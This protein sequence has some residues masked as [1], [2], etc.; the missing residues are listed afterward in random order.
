MNYMASSLKGTSNEDLPRVIERVQ[1]TLNESGK[2]GLQSEVIATAMIYL[3]ENP[4]V[5]I[6][7][8]LYI[9]LV[10]WDI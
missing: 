3:K 7:E 5:S 10:D 2:S 1:T 8:A 4:E 6:Q 9:G